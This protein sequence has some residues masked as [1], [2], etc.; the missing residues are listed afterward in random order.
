MKIA[1]LDDYQDV[2]RHLPCFSLLGEHEVKV[3]HH[4]AVGIGQLAIRLAPFDA[5][6]LIRERTALPRA[7]LNKL[8]KLKIIAQTGKFGAHVDIVAAKERGIALLEGSGD[9]TAPA[10]LTWALILAASRKLVGYATNLQSGTW[11]TASMQSQH[12]G[13][14]RVLR[15]RCLGIWGFGKIGSRVAAFGKAFGMQV[16]VW[17]SAESRARAEQEGYQTSTTKDAFFQQADVLS[18]HLRL[19][20]A[21]RG[22]VTLDDLLKMKA[23]ALL[24]NTSRAELIDPNALVSALDQ[25]RPGFAAIDV[26]EQEPVPPQHPLL[27]RAN[28]LATPHLGYVEQDSYELY[29]RTA[30]QNLLDHLAA[31]SANHQH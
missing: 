26:F 14:G 3:F 28:V 16:V 31:Q 29:F 17:G 20:D 19:H 10:E 30:F 22:I 8:P 6:V 18:L 24:V 27:H 11:Q 13:L 12:N 25:G 15:G 5:L 21:T 7:L 2:V 23:D 1:I 4:S 9:P